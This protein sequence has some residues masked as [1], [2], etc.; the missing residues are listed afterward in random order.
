MGF[1]VDCFPLGVN[2]FD[3]DLVY[4][5]S[6]EHSCVASVDLRTQEFTLYQERETW[7]DCWRVNTLG[8]K[9][10]MEPIYDPAS[11]I[12]L[13]QFVLPQWMDPVPRPPN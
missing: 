9:E 11:V 5:W 12:T 7:S 10:H 2:P 8:T 1:D 3:T 6:R 13:S 4:I